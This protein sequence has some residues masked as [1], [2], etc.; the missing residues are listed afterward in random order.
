MKM[1]GLPNFNTKTDV[2][3]SLKLFPYDARVKLKKMYDDRYT[4]VKTETLL[5]AEDGINDDTHVVS[6]LEEGGYVQLEKVVDSNAAIYR[7]GFSDV[8]IQEL[9]SEI[10][11]Y[12]DKAYNESVTL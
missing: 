12:N 9:I 3:N 8:E 6:E 7:L 11:K 10:D 2:E 5:M 4:W 1:R